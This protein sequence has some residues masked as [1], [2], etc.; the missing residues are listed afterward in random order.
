[1]SPQLKELYENA[2]HIFN[3]HQKFLLY[4]KKIDTD[5]IYDQSLDTYFVGING[6][7]VDYLSLLYSYHTNKNMPKYEASDAY[8][9]ENYGIFK[10]TAGHK[11]LVGQSFK[12]DPALF[13]IL[14]DIERIKWPTI[15]SPYLNYTLTPE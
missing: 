13:P 11:I 5:F 4:Y 14:R 3:T 12:L 8:I 7:H 15:S 10:S 6:A 1:M 9:L 2:T